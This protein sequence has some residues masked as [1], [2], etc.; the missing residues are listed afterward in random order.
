MTSAAAHLPSLLQSPTK[1]ASAKAVSTGATGGSGTSALSQSKPRRR[2]R[3]Y[4]RIAVRCGCWLEHEEATVFG[5]TVDLGRGGLFLRTALPMPPG[6]SVRVTLRLPGQE[7]VVADGKIVRTVAP[8]AGDRPG[9]GV[10]FDALPNGDDQLCAFLFGSMREQQQ[11]QG[12][13][14][15]ALELGASDLRALELAP[16]DTSRLG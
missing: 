9:L 12:T 5:T 6:I 10:R 13:S 7:T 11:E 8:H 2:A 16:A 4:Q 3:E 1:A 14:A 15:G